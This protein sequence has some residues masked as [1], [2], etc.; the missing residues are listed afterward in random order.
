MKY[1]VSN[2]TV[3]PPDTAVSTFRIVSELFEYPPH[4]WASPT[5]GSMSTPGA[6][7]KFTAN[8]EPGFRNTSYDVPRLFALRGAS[9]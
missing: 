2:V 8:C 7:L 6:P 1:H 3:W 4:Q 5:I 9:H